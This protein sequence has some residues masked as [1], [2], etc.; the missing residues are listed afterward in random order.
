MKFEI[1]REELLKPLQAVIGV[2]ERRQT[3]PVL[4]NVLVVA[5]GDLLTITATDLEVELAARVEARIATPGR[6]TLPARKLM[7]IVRNLPTAVRI[8]VSVDQDKAQIVAARSRFTLATLPAN[9]FP[10]VDGIGER[11]PLA[12]LRRESGAEAG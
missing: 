2:V 10:L 4:A 11:S 1:D 9:D 7:D 12:I 3:L 8:Q 5:E 6:I